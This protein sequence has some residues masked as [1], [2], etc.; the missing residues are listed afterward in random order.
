MTVYVKIWIA[1]DGKAVVSIL[2]KLHKPGNHSF[3]LKKKRK[4]FDAQVQSMVPK[5]GGLN[6][7]Y[8]YD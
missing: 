8:L 2:S 3:D 7:L 6:T 4:K 5:F 1:E